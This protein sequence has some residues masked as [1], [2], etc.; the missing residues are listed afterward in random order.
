MHTTLLTLVAAITIAAPVPKAKVVWSDFFPTVVGTKWVFDHPIEGDITL[1]VTESDRKDG[2]IRWTVQQTIGDDTEVM[3][4]VATKQGVVE[5]HSRE[6]FKI[7]RWVM[8][9]PL[10]QDESWEFEPIDHGDAKPTTGKMTTGRWSDVRV[11]AGRYYAVSVVTE[12]T[13][14]NIERKGKP[15]VH[16]W[17]TWYAPGVGVVKVKIEQGLTRKLKSFTPGKE[18]PKKDK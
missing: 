12:V 13:D 17:T 3:K 4:Y 18:E 10:K 8:R 9:F 7:E 11:P 16:T 15:V 14:P 6:E 5:Q 2:E 1:E